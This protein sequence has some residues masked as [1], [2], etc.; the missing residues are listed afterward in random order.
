MYCTNC[1]TRNVAGSQFCA[2]CGAPL[3][4]PSVD[5]PTFAPSPPEP[6]PPT[7][8]SL[9]PPPLWVAPPPNPYPTFLV[10]QRSFTTPAVITMALYIVLWLPGLIAN[11]IYLNEA[12]GIQRRSGRAPEGIGCLW[13]LLIVFTILPVLGLCAFVGLAMLGGSTQ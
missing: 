12:K 10:E 13:A 1:G 4:K 5:P 3:I 6:P 7:A 2:E 8:E 11:I 9:Y